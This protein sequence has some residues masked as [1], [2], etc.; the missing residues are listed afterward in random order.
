MPS[1]PGYKS[2]LWSFSDVAVLIFSKDSAKKFDSWLKP[3]CAGERSTEK[4]LQKIF[5]KMFLWSCDWE[6]IRGWPILNYPPPSIPG[7]RHSSLTQ[8]FVRLESSFYLEKNWTTTTFS[9]EGHQRSKKCKSEKQ[10]KTFSSFN[11][12][13]L[14][15]NKTMWTTLSWLP[16]S[17]KSST[18]KPVKKTVWPD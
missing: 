3:L 13:P 16:T 12:F 8:W 2:Q 7:K 14:S 11:F 17:I 9:L 1:R 10:L 5:E 4:R 15:S 6:S 18:N